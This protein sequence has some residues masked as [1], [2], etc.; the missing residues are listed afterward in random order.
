M[1]SGATLLVIRGP[2]SKYSNP[3]KM[4]SKTW[5]INLTSGKSFSDDTRTSTWVRW[6]TIKTTR[7][8]VTLTTKGKRVA[9]ATATASNTI[10]WQKPKT[11][12]GMAPSDHSNQAPPPTMKLA[13]VAPIIGPK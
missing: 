10:T 6:P 8:V 3:G 1:G 7:Q 5:A 11:R 2:R 4:Y 13:G 12:P 9:R